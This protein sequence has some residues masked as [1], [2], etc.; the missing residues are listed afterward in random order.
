[1]T[2][3]ITGGSGF[4]GSNF[5]HNWLRNNDETIINLDNLTLG[6]NF[7][8]TEIF[9]KNNKYKFIKGDINN[10]VLVNKLLF[11]N[12]PRAIINMAAETHVDK[13]ISNPRRFVE[14]NINGTFSLLEA[15]HN[16]W[17]NLP[18]VEKKDFRY[19]QVSTDEVYGALKKDS[20]PFDELDSFRPNN[21]YS[22]SKAAADHLVRSFNRTY[23]LPTITTHCSN[24]YGPYQSFDKLIPL[25]ITNSLRCKKLPIYGNG[26]NIR[27]WI[28]V[29]DHC[30]AVKLILHKG[31]IGESYN[32]GSENEKTNIEI[33]NEICNLLDELKPLAE[34]LEFEKYFELIEYVKDRPGHDFRYSINA[35]KIKKELNWCPIETFETGIKKTIEWYLVNN[36][37][38]EQLTGNLLIF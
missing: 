20:K 17:K 33:V 21:P 18:T 34:N 9:K 22:A 6:S 23:G 27:D 35:S 5:V 28:Y 4:I 30:E 32:I 25:I 16:Y 8:K 29:E 24:N 15:T 13:S 2:I 10:S 3:L 37:R 38:V 19:L 11:Q 12:K 7:I 36:S 14:S 26:T 1:M 31:K